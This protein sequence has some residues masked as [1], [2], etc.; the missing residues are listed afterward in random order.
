MV[1]HSDRQSVASSPLRRARVACK[2]C[3]A[4]RVKC[5]AGESQPCWQCRMRRIDCEL[6]ESRRGRYS[7]RKLGTHDTRQTVQHAS[8]IEVTGVD[9]LPDVTL[10]DAT[11]PDTTRDNGIIEPGHGTR[12]GY[13]LTPS[14]RVEDHGEDD[15]TFLPETNQPNHTQQPQDGRHRPNLLD[16][17]TEEPTALSYI[18]E[19]TYRPE[20]GSSKALEVRHPIPASIADH[21]LNDGNPVYKQLSLDEALLMPSRDIA[22]QLVYTFFDKMHPAYPVLDREAF[23][24]AYLNG[25]ASSLVLQTI[26]LLGFTVGSDELVHAAGFRDRT[27]ARKTYYLRAKAL[28]DADYESDRVLLV[29]VMLLLGFWWSGPDDQKDTCHWVGCATTLAQSLG[30][31]RIVSQPAMSQR[32][33]SLRRRIW[34][35]IYMRDRHTSQAFGR[36]CRIRDEDCDVEPLSEE[37]LAFDL[38]YDQRVIPIQRDYHVSYVLEMSKLTIILG[39][40]LTAEFSPRRDSLE[41]FQTENLAQRIVQW[42]AGLPDRLQIKASERCSGASLW[43][44][45][46]Q[47]NYQNCKIL[48]FRPKAIDNL[49]SAQR[50]RDIRARTA[51]DTITR[52]AEDFLAT[53]MISSALIHLVPALFSALSIH[54]IVI[55]RTDSYQR[56]L[57]ENKSRQCMLA[58]SVIAKSWPVRIWISQSFVNLMKRLTGPDA[59]SSGPIVSVSSS[60]A[61]S[62][63][64][65][66]SIGPG[67]LPGVRND[68]SQDIGSYISQSS[69]EQSSHCTCATGPQSGGIHAYGCLWKAA[70][71]FV[72]DSLWAGYLDSAM[73]V[74]FFLHNY[75]GPAQ[76]THLEGDGAAVEST[77][78]R[79]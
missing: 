17:S 30:F 43:A 15:N 19:L 13:L 36:P 31:H 33:K 21:T 14:D 41:K 10:T 6:V 59:V 28:Y 53:D 64:N 8:D 16:R 24:L 34:W 32:M 60:I 29:A 37:D 12:T 38:G 61:T 66:V 56:Q 2:A 3:N 73:D 27:T 39:D 49:S 35:T 76:Y 44:S 70:D 40:I 23:S 45:L 67:N 42:E 54:T 65:A 55:C 4:R 18:I 20:G 47:F 7:R 5:D 50:E 25:R 11:L 75:I 63:R 52:L 78:A 51:A 46:L 72:H 57:A 26:F 9:T 48:L 62:A 79:S 58:L 22:D 77:N 1:D 69:F 71:Q 68:H 74:D